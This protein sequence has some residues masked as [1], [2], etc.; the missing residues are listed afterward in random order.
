MHKKKHPTFIDLFSGCGGFSLGLAQAQWQGV[1]GIEK[2][3]DAYAT[4]AANFLYGQETYKFQ[5]PAWLEPRAHSIDDVLT[6]YREQLIR[7]QGSIDVIAGGPP[8]QGF[9]Y[10]GKRKKND[11]RNLMFERYVEFVDLVRPSALIL[12]NVPGMRVAHGMS[13]RRERVMPGPTPKSYYEKLVEALDAIG[14][15]AIGKILDASSFGVPQ[16]RPRLF[17]IGIK[18]ELVSS[19]PKGITEIFDY[20]ERSRIELLRD[21]GLHESVSTKDAISDLEIK[22]GRPTADCR[23]PASRAGF[24][25]PDYQGPETTYQTLMHEKVGIERMDS[26]RLANHRKE[27][28]KRFEKILAICKKGV[29]LSVKDRKMLGMLKHR[30][31]PIDDKRPA[32]TVTTLPDDILHYSEPRILS[33][34]ESARLQS[35][36]DWFKFLGKY[37]TGG[38]RRK[39]DCPRF[40]QVGNAVPPLMARVI[41]I[42]LAKFLKT[43]PH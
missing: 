10:A 40:T 25:I 4:F 2:A 1:F 43:L 42:G 38:H 22:E 16:K 8:C 3:E 28:T 31:V 21:L 35:F 20:V 29:S 18:E 19:L 15:K 6:K 41:G 17:V 13:A 24:R 5:W 12:E 14:Y 32:P 26:M 36:P 9:S 34:R 33:V 11:P 23:D 7:L 30:T 27:V 37:T 39:L